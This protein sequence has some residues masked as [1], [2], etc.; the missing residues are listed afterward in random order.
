MSHKQNNK[1]GFTLIELMV[2]IAIIG[3]LAGG[4]FTAY[5]RGLALNI[6]LGSVNEIDALIKETHSVA[7]A[8]R[9]QITAQ[10]NN[11]EEIDEEIKPIGITLTT[12]NTKS[13]PDSPQEL[14]SFQD[15]NEN[16]Q[17]DP[18]DEVIRSISINNPAS[19]K[20]I[21]GDTLQKLT[22][23]YH[24]P[25]ATANIYKDEDFSTSHK[26]ASFMITD[27]FGNYKRGKIF[28]FL[29]STG[30]PLTSDLK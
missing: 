22:I 26:T 21:E 9:A 25:R 2:V 19:I 7:I 1:S 8:S 12:N 10:Q 29:R 15:L 24:P 23:I 17:F 27:H 3:M 18:A 30:I 4:A 13:L 6:Y 5:Q 14:F 20:A 11:E 28:K 16:N